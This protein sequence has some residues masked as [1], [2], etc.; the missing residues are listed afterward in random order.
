[1]ST[2]IEMKPCPFCGMASDLE[3]ADTLYPPGTGWRFDNDLQMRTY[4]SFREV[5][6]AQWCWTMHCPETAGGC[7]AEITGD[8][9]DEA[10]RKW[11]TR[12]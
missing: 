10:I 1:M 6:R 7:G 5:P 11:N 2:Q 9:R 3:D 4:H 12:A 8:S